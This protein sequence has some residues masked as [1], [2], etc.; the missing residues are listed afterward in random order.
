MTSETGSIEAQAGD[1]PWWLVLLEG[2]ALIIVG[3]LLLVSRE[4]T[5]IILVQFI[6]IYWLIKGIFDIVSIFIDSTAWGWKL[7]IGIVGIIAGLLIL[8]HPL[9]SAI[10]VP[11]VMV[12]IL[13]IYAM[14]AGIVGIVRAFQGAGWG[15]GVLGVAAILLGIFFLANTLISAALLVSLS[16]LVAIIGGIFAII[17]AFRLR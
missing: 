11:G 16:A 6:G 8:Q 12:W 15:V 5:L 14:V 1:R 7:L 3:V 17:M 9:W 10:L 13:G 4:K 2:I